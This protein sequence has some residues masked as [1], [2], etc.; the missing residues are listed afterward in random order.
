MES[1]AISEI[2][3]ICRKIYFNWWLPD[4]LMIKLMSCAKYLIERRRRRCSKNYTVKIWT[5]AETH[6]NGN[7]FKPIF[8]DLEIEIKF[9]LSDLTFFFCVTQ[10]TSYVIDWL[11]FYCARKTDSNLTYLFGKPWCYKWHLECVAVRMQCVERFRRNCTEHRK[12][13][14][15]KLITNCNKSKEKNNRKFG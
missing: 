7:V 1:Y 10:P 13:A 12:N 8:N 5:T 9:P 14:S 3:T 6:R 4:Y 11:R 2:S 15:W